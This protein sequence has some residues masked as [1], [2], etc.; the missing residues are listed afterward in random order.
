MSEKSKTKPELLAPAGRMETLFAA[1]EA[2]ADAVYVGTQ[3]FN[4][5]MR[6]PNCRS[7]IALGALPGRKP[8]SLPNL[9]NSPDMAANSA[10]TC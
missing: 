10:S 2:G 6:A 1:L 8:S 3:D 5:R 4:A 9:W 7:T